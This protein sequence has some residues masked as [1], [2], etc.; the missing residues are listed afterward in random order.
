MPGN[1]G[2]RECGEERGRNYTVVEYFLAAGMSGRGWRV[3]ARVGAA[4]AQEWEHGDGAGAQ[5]NGAGATGCIGM[6]RRV[7][8]N[9][10][11][12]L[13]AAQGWVGLVCVA[14]SGGCRP[15]VGV[16]VDGAPREANVQQRIGSSRAAQTWGRVCAAGVSG[17]A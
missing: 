7:N 16:C 1:A 12:E 5:A 11:R 2:A 3:D 15:C 14:R 4:A 8:V 13:P 10:R 9:A 17:Y 6:G